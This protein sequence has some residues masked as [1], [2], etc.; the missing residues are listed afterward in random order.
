MTNKNAMAYT[1]LL[2]CMLTGCGPSSYV[3][4]LEND[5]GSTG[6]I[7]VKSTKGDSLVVD[8]AQSA[9]ALD[10]SVQPA[11]QVSTETL[12]EEFGAALAARP[13][14]PKSFI[15]KFESGGAKLTA[16]SEALLPSVIEEIS[17]HPGA[18]ISIIGH[19]DTAGDASKNVALGLIRAQFVANKL[20]ERNINVAGKTITSHGES[21]PIKPTPDNTD[22]A[23][24]RRVE[25]T[26]R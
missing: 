8:K 12:Q 19:T 26:V 15:L 18:D 11:F 20:D 14:N 2:A 24:N 10:G 16:E 23:E 9:A 3:V 5:N 6:A 17:K 4:L 22:E 7:E 13:I 1:T 21:N 25:V